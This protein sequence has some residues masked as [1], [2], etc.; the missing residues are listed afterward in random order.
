MA[1]LFRIPIPLLEFP[2]AIVITT[3]AV[4]QTGRQTGLQDRWRFPILFHP[5]CARRLPVS[6]LPP[7]SVEVSQGPRR[8]GVSIYDLFAA[9]RKI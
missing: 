7:K 8:T 1:E 4:C 3:S 2:L 5:H 6:A 9:P